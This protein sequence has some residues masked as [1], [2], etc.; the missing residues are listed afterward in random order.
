VKE[1]AVVLKCKSVAV[2]L[3]QLAL[4]VQWNVHIAVLMIK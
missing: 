4:Q 3:S 1:H 2:A